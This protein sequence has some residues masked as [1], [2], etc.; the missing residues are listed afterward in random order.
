M[1]RALQTALG[2]NHEVLTLMRRLLRERGKADYDL[3]PSV[4]PKGAEDLLDAGFDLFDAIDALSPVDIRKVADELY[5]I[6]RESA[7]YR[8]RSP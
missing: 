6:E 5:D 8:A 7:R 4:A 1:Q 3:G 2:D